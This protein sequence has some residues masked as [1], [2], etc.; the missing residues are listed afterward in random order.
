MRYKMAVGFILAVLLVITTAFSESIWIHGVEAT[1]GVEYEI[2]TEPVDDKWLDAQIKDAGLTDSGIITALYVMNT[3][4]Y[5]NNGKPLPDKA[6]SVEKLCQ[7]MEMMTFDY[8]KESIDGGVCLKFAETTRLEL[9][10]TE[11]K[12]DKLDL[13]IIGIQNVY[14]NDLRITIE[15]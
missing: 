1:D 7:W 15:L 8:Q 13:V 6:R 2:E 9:Y 10:V 11:N 4:Q 5:G 3:L 12:I 14:G